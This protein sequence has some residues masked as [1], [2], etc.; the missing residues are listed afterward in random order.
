GFSSPDALI[1]AGYTSGNA[2]TPTSGA[3][4]LNDYCTEVAIPLLKDMA[5]AQSLE[6]SA[7]VRYS[8]YNTF[9]STTNSKFGFKWKPVADL[10][11]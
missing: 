8:D 3:Y 1:S 7:A 2:F 5:G 9:G 10:L 11:I 4:T 6:L